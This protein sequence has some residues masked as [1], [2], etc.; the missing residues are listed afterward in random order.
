MLQHEL[1]YAQNNLALWVLC[2]TSN[3]QEGEVHLL[4]TEQQGIIRTVAAKY[5]VPADFALGIIDKESA[6]KVTY[7]VNGRQLPAIR[8]EGHYFYK[9]L[10]GDK[11]AQAVKAGLAAKKAG[12]VKNPTSMAGRYALLQRMA[13]VDADAAYKS[14]SMGIGQIMGA[15]YS[16][17][18]FDTPQK[19]FLRMLD[20]E[21]QAAVMMRF[22]ENDPVL[23]KAAQT[24]QYQTF[25]KRYNGPAMSSS[26]PRDLETFT[27]RY[28]AAVDAIDPYEIKL[29]E[30]G[31]DDAKTFQTEKGLVVDGIVGKITREAI[32]AEIKK[33]A[34]IANKPVVE[35]TV[36]G[37]VAAGTGT[38]VAMAT[39]TSVI[40]DTITAVQPMLETIHSFAP[41]GTGVVIAVSV[42]VAAFALYKGVGVYL[43][44]RKN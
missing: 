33:R 10:S 22:I 36:V 32:E 38:V 21:G 35:S 17:L 43:A 11:Q 41:M 42:V 3:Q 8:I 20:L 24:Y 29:K 30:L 31:Y 27:K 14:I 1:G 19:M 39:N 28:S 23:L 12:V 44:N 5:K 6:G 13:D 40:Q 2:C 7:D 15:H 34:E 16:S 4:N 18:G 25:G 9:Y 26:Y 37:T